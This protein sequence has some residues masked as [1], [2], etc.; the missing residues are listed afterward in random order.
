MGHDFMKKDTGIR[1]LPHRAVATGEADI[2]EILLDSRAGPNA[3]DKNGEQHQYHREYLGVRL[4]L[5]VVEPV[6]ISTILI[7]DYC[8]HH[9]KEE[10]YL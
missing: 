2:L 7:Q 10:C 1:V 6:A 4:L 9:Q 8:H 3:L 5:L